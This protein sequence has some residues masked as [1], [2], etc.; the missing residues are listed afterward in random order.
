MCFNVIKPFN[1][2]LKHLVKI[3][4]APTPVTEAWAKSIQYNFNFNLC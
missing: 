4:W 2:S 1:F 3:W